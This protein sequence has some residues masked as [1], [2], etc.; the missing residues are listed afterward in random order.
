MYRWCFWSYG[1]VVF[2]HA[3]VTD[4]EH[5]ASQGASDHNGQQHEAT[6][7]ELY[8]CVEEVFTENIVNES[9][10]AGESGTV[11]GGCQTVD[12]IGDKT[13]ESGSGSEEGI[14]VVGEG[15]EVVVKVIVSSKEC[16]ELVFDVLVK[17]GA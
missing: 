8:R 17:V 12:L 14:Q 1:S 4:T 5:A 10:V 3:S 15:D 11:T 2:L 6:N 16:I 13:L 9:E 7:T